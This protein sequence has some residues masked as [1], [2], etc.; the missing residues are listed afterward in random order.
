M[1]QNTKKTSYWKEIFNVK[2]ICINALI[3]ALY[4]VLTYLGNFLG[5]SYSYMQFRFSEF[6]VLLVFFNSHYTLGL[7]LGCLL[8][9]FAS[10]SGI[11]DIVLGTLA[12]FISCLLMILF[13][14]KVKS[15]FLTGLIPC[16]V[17]AFMVPLIIY[18]ASLN[19][20]DAF[21]FTPMLYFVMWGWVLLGEI[22]SINVFG[23]IIFMTLKL[24]K[25]Y[26]KIINA[27]RNI[28]FKW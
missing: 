14:K 16:F 1:E 20:T 26:D 10:S 3:A 21:S 9:N 13:S 24:Y 18:L 8:A 2:T 15:L 25:G 5:L 12:T 6:L 4:A 7:T 11:Y 27:N 22:L 17:N 28:D 19:T 23:Y